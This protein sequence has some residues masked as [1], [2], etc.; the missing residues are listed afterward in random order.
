M[1]VLFHTTIT[2][3]FIRNMATL[4]SE[5]IGWTYLLPL[6]VLGPLFFERGHWGQVGL[7]RSL[8]LQ[9]T[10]REGL[11]MLVSDS[12]AHVALQRRHLAHTH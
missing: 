7:I 11:A 12:V 8:S 4:T 10:N 1:P 3:V 6:L 5:E 2:R 9:R